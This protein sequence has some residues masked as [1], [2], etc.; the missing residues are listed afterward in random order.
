MTE[1]ATIGHNGAPDPIADCTALY[2]DVISEAQNWADGE[3]VTDEKSMLAVDEIIKGFKTYRTALT[4]AGK[5]RTDPP[6]KA[7]KAEVAAVKV[8]TDD[9]DKLQSC[10][11]AIVAPFKAKLAAQKEAERRAAWEA[12]NKAARDAE[13]AAAK[14]NPANIDDQRAAEVAKQSALDAQ[15]AAS[16]AQKDTVKGMRTVKHFEVMDF[17]NMLRWLNKNDRPA[18]EHFCIEY[19]RRTSH[20]GQAIDGVREWITKEAF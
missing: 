13:A 17:S 2:D 1:L 6:H 12:A 4:K 15:K 14:A 20:N 19:A 18:L 8:Y 3:P 7:W 5:E 16:A 9:A 11:V 10:L